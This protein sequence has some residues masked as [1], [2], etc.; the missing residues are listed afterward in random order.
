MK[1]LYQDWLTDAGHKVSISKDQTQLDETIAIAK[2]VGKAE[3]VDYPFEVEISD[4]GEG[5]GPALARMVQDDTV[6]LESDEEEVIIWP[7]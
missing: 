7:E 4:E 5:I 1:V 6:F 3:P 2:K